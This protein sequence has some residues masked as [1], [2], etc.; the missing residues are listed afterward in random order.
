MLPKSDIMMG[1][2][3]LVML[4]LLSS[5]QNAPPEFPKHEAQSTSEAKAKPRA[6]ITDPKAE[7]WD[8][9]T[10]KFRKVLLGD[11]GGYQVQ[12]LRVIDPAWEDVDLHLP[13]D[14]K[15]PLHEGKYYI[16]SIVTDGYYNPI[17]G[18]V[19][20]SSVTKIV[21]DGM[22]LFDQ[23][24]CELHGRKMKRKSLPLV[25][26]DPGSSFRGIPFKV[27]MEQMPH[28]CEYE[29]GGCMVDKHC[30]TTRK[31]WICPACVKAADDWRK[32]HRIP[33]RDT[34]PAALIQF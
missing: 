29:F 4:A 2:R 6:L 30:P 7:R 5:C 26:G 1:G 15:L 21:H 11:E 10:A 25:Y 27:W 12:V 16:F 13:E 23:S 8:V 31:D 18:W 19:N 14:T 20:V 28:G 3:C 33:D 22:T 32:A 9:V 34:G 24:L 17:E